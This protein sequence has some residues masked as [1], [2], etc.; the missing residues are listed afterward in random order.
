MDDILKDLKENFL[1]KRASGDRAAQLIKMH[2]EV[3]LLAQQMV[4]VALTVG[5]AALHL[6]CTD[7]S[8]NAKLALVEGAVVDLNFLK[9]TSGFYVSTNSLMVEHHPE[10]SVSFPVSERIAQVLDFILKPIESFK[11]HFKYSVQQAKAT[12]A[13]KKA[14]DGTPVVLPP[15]PSC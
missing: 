4:V 13:A 5:M 1:D 12:E 9:L 7:V 11:P 8:L 2:A 3:L 6:S 15:A 10:H 14:A